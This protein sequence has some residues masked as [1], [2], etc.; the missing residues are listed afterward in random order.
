MALPAIEVTEVTKSFKI[1]QEKAQS[2]KERIIKAGRNP[3]IDFKALDDI[4]FEV[5][6]GETFA[7]LGHNGS[8][9]STLLKCIA[10]TLRPTSGRIISRGRLAA[11]LELGAGFHPDLTGRENIYLNG[12]IL[13]F[14]RP[15]VEAIFDDIVDFAEL[16]DFIDQ[17]VK[18]YSSGMYARLGFSVAINVEP[19]IL[20]VDEVLAV[21]DEAFQ[22]KCIDRV[23]KLQAEGRTILLVS[24]AAELVRQIADRAAVFDH[25]HLV[26]VTEPGE[27]IRTLRE[28]LARRGIALLTEEE[29]AA[30][31]AAAASPGG[32]DP[33]YS[34][35]PSASVPVID[36][37]KP[38]VITKVQAEYPEP[39]A[40]YLLPNQPMRLRIDYVAPER[41]TDICFA[42]EIADLRSNLIF[43]TDT[44]TLEQPISHVDG[45]GAVC[46][47]L[48]RVPLLD[49]T[50]TIAVTATSRTGGEVY[51]RR[52]HI[53]HFEV[54]QPGR[55]RGTVALDPKVTH[56]FN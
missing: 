8:G 37:D 52:D 55:Q 26:D 48:P 12:S 32:V 33:R 42:F 1:Y 38:L 46:F 27:A 25:G 2:A 6:E 7:L 5:A 29:E 23:R 43:G 4:S 31:A 40:R 35:P 39:T 49:G 11:L 21:G 41:L 45:V 36:L 34:G 18:H 56:F 14:S 44:Q 28:T 24:H 51:D 22:R 9:K 10:G 16:W 3:H 19:E 54:M 15:Q 47:D 50:F 30:D 17:Q 13:G 53:D 20:L